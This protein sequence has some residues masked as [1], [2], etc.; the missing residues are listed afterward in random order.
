MVV[1]IGHDGIC[2]SQFLFDKSFNCCFKFSIIKATLVVADGD[3]AV[4]NL[5]DLENRFR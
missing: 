2:I 4:L 5:I 3:D 1:G